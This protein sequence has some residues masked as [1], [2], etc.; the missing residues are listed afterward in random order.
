MADASTPATRLSPATITLAFAALLAMI[1]IGIVIGR[2]SAGGGEE[3][4]NASANQAAAQPRAGSVDAM[5]AALRERLR[6]NPDDDNGWYML[7]MSYRQSGRFA[8][9][10]QAFRRASELAPRNA[11]YLAYLGEILLAT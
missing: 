9:A 7:G 8:E 2:A 1:A 6:Q 4:G 5:A 11:D 10:E 3:T